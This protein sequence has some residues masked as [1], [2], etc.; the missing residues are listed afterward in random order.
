MSK[1]IFISFLV[2]HGTVNCFAQNQNKPIMDNWF[3]PKDLEFKIPQNSTPPDPPGVP[4]DGGLVGLIAAGSVVGYKKY[5]A[6][7]GEK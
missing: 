6:R 2:I 7:L 5:K 3:S 1:Y 4:L